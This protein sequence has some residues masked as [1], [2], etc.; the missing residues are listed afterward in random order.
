MNTAMIFAL[1]VFVT[2]IVA[3]ASAMVGVREASD[4]TQSRRNELTD[5]EWALVE[6]ERAKQ[7]DGGDQP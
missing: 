2:L 7:P 3:A 5:W 4:P 1:G 6:R